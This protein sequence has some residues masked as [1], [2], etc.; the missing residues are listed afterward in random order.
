MPRLLEFAG[1]HPYLVGAAILIVLLFVADTLLRRLRKYREVPPAEAVRLINQ[2]AA[3]LD[4]RAA[5]N[6]DSGHVIG[7]RNIPGAELD[8]RLP[9]LDKFREQPL[10]V[11]CQSG[12]TSHAHAAALAKAGFQQVFSLKGGIAAWQS[13]NFPLEKH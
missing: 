2:G 5:K 13:E 3:V 10:L 6:F 12:N 11:Y 9:E 1:H 8:G 7:A 4:L